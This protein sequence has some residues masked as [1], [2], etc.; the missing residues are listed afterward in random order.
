MCVCVHVSI[1]GRGE[2]GGGRGA[3]GEVNEAYQVGGNT[4]LPDW[5]YMASI[6]IFS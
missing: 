4:M 5:M 2:G 1:G 3:G 6:L